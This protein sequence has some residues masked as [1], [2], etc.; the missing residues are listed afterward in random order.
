M[1]PAMSYRKADMG[2][3]TSAMMLVPC[4]ALEGE[5]GPDESAQVLTRKYGKDPLRCLDQELTHAGALRG[6][7]SRVAPPP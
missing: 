6:L 1:P 7:T 2:S 4:S 3:L 5:T